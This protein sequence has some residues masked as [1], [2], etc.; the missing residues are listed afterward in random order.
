MENQKFKVGDIVGFKG[1]GLGLGKITTITLQKR[2]NSISYP[3][4]LVTL[5]KKN[6]L[7]T[8]FEEQ[9]EKLLSIAWWNWDEQKI[10]D[11]AMDMWS[12]NINDFINKFYENK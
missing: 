2:R 8:C 1:R 6:F 10:K 9:I 3:F 7:V 11:N 5:L 12:D 4:Y